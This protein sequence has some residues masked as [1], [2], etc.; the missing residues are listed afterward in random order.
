ML[1][2]SIMPVFTQEGLNLLTSVGVYQTMIDYLYGA[3]LPDIAF[4]VSSFAIR[5]T[6]IKIASLQIPGFNF[7]LN[8]DGT[9]NLG[10]GGVNISLSLKFNI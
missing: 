3:Q 9:V 6:D 5:F 2:A 4:S 8:E 10:E 1:D 7:V